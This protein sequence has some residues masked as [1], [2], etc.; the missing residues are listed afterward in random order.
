MTY[1]I[2]V[3]FSLDAN[4]IYVDFTMKNSKRKDKKDMKELQKKIKQRLID[5]VS[6]YL[7]G[8][9]RNIV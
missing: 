7:N 4:D 3:F 1:E 2:E 8:T 6:S 5:D 9:I